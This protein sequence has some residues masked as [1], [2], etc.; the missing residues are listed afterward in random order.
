M[1][2]LLFAVSSKDSVM[3]VLPVYSCLRLQLFLPRRS[4]EYCISSLKYPPINWF[5]I[6]YSRSWPGRIN[7]W[8]PHLILT[9]QSESSSL[10]L[11]VRVF[12]R[13]PFTRVCLCWSMHESIPQRDK[14]EGVNIWRVQMG[15]WY[16]D[17]KNKSCYKWA[18]EPVSLLWVHVNAVN[19][20]DTR[21]LKVLN[22]RIAAT[23]FGERADLHTDMKRLHSFQALCS[24]TLSDISGCCCT[25]QQ[26]SL[27]T[28]DAP[29]IK[30]QQW[31]P[32][33]SAAGL[34]F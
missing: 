32:T 4:A 21:F 34:R 25:S 33:Y 17:G 30:G 27:Q 2:P 16:W 28:R 3:P 15:L 1:R 29:M 23:L 9:S 22:T 11:S 6:S 26:Q 10:C 24:F 12:S 14:S 7:R 13:A 19:L 5:N 18:S 31:G 8:K 20:Q